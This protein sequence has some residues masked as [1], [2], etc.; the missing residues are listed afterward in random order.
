MLLTLSSRAPDKGFLPPINA[1]RLI[2]SEI[3]VT[4]SA[5]GGINDIN[6]MLALA[7]SK[8]IKPWIETRP[9]SDANQA[10][11]DFEA[12]KA[13]FRYVLVNEKHAKINSAL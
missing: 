5:I 4:G 10:I 2:N 6:E 7:S 9:L 8:N 13:R 1:F 11:I 12:G 3:K